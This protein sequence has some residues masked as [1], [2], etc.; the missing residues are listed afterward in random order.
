MAHDALILPRGRRPTDWR[1][2]DPFGGLAG[3]R[4]DITPPNVQ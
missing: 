1:P 4:L 3:D 2:A